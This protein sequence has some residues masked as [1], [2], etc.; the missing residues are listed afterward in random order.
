MENMNTPSSEDKVTSFDDAFE[1]PPSSLWR[2]AMRHLVRK[3]SAVVGMVI[4]G[5][6]VFIAIFH[7]LLATHDPNVPMLDIPEEVEMGVPFD[8]W[9]ESLAFKLLFPYP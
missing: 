8:P 6:L 5:I 1:Q 9:S 3:R 4:L 7:P 2:D